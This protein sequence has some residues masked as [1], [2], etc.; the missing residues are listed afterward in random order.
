M[1]AKRRSRRPLRCPSRGDPLPPRGRRRLVFFLRAGGGSS[2]SSSPAAPLFFISRR[3]S[4]FFLP[5]GGSPCS[6]SRPVVRRCPS[7][8]SLPTGVLHTEDQHGVVL[9]DGSEFKKSTSGVTK[10]DDE[11]TGTRPEQGMST[12]TVISR[13]GSLCATEDRDASSYRK[14]E[15]R[16]MEFYSYC[17]YASFVKQLGY[18][19]ETK[20]V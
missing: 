14:N 17:T 2:S 7:S 12:T 20:L 9:V 5:G 16:F 10:E 1:A 6:S 15:K 13:Q 4:L 11:A 19:L 18:L 8:S 3:H